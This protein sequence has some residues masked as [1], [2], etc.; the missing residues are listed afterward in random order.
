M[1]ILVCLK[2]VPTTGARILLT[3]DEQEIDT[4][5]LGFAM[6]PHEE[7]AVEAGVQ[8]IEQ[9]GGSLTVLTL[10][11]EEAVEQLRYALAMGADDAILLA[12]SG[13]V[14]PMATAGAITAAI[15]ERGG[16]ENSFDLLLFGNEAADSG[17]YQVGIR[18]AHALGLPC[19]TG[20]KRLDVTADGLEV[21]RE[22]GTGWEVYRVPLPAVI[23]IREGI[24]LPRYPSVPGRLR[25]KKKPV[26]TV[27]PHLVEGGPEKIRLVNPPE[28]DHAVQ[29]LGQGPAAVPRIVELLQELRLL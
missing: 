14:D 1:K 10:G 21:R 29:I 4:R 3:A 19:V 16:G 22:A 25:A 15:R 5:N 24:N 13:D 27:E 7:C 26:E 28:Q 9:H 20:V 2:R 6:S 17:G 11:P 8:L 12:A 18:V 23:T